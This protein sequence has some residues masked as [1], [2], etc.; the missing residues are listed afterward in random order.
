MYTPRARP[1]NE[2]TGPKTGRTIRVGAKIGVR[3][4]KWGFW[5][6][7]PVLGVPGGSGGVRGPKSDP[8]RLCTPLEKK[9]TYGDPP[10]GPH[11]SHSGQ[12]LYP[13]GEPGALSKYSWLPEKPPPGGFW[14]K[15]TIRAILKIWAG[16]LSGNF[17]FRQ[18][19]P[20]NHIEKTG[21]KNFLLKID[22]TK[23]FTYRVP[24]LPKI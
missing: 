20:K 21:E 16:F 19:R 24:K 17:D 9:A 23:G 12:T 14:P 22:L 7:F 15:R 8:A 5:P 18:N 1:A 6:I 11:F 2:K 3:G 10:P 4:P 13:P